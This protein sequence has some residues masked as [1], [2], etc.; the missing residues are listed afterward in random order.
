MTQYNCVSIKVSN[1]QLNELKSGIKNDTEATLNLPSSMI[2]N[3][4]DETNSLHKSLLTNWHVSR[5][6]K[7]FSNNNC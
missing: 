1:S 3:Y 4:S 6:C 7:A 5:L 2:G